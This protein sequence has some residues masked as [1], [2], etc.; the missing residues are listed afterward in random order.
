LL[1]VCLL[2]FD[3]RLILREFTVDSLGKKRLSPESFRE[4]L[5]LRE[6]TVDSLQFRKKKIEAEV[7]AEVELK[8]WGVCEGHWGEFSVYWS[9]STFHH[10]QITHY[11]FL[12]L[13]SVI[14]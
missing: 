4:R 14:T 5:R 6:F 9:T 7:E 8:H 10:Y 13:K 2:G 11:S 3:E 12:I 1:L